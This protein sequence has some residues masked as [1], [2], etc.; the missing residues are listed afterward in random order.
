MSPSDP[1]GL[2]T[3]VAAS[4]RHRRPIRSWWAGLHSGAGSC[5]PIRRGARSARPSQA[6]GVVT[7]R[8]G[9]CARSPR[10]GSTT[11][12]NR[13]ESRGRA[14]GGPVRRGSP[15]QRTRPEAVE[16][17]PAV[18]EYFVATHGEKAVNVSHSGIVVGAGVC[19][20]GLGHLCQ[21]GCCG[22]EPRSSSPPEWRSSRS[23]RMGRAHHGTRRPP[24]QGAL[25]SPPSRSQLG[26]APTADEQCSAVAAVATG[27]FA[28]ASI[29]S[30]PVRRFQH[31]SAC[32]PSAP[33]LG[34][35]C[36]R[37]SW[38]SAE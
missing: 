31:H 4:D 6:L 10:A 27:R 1:A 37:P 7:V 22:L 5:R 14:C 2:L 15:A 12:M 32:R 35:L 30:V 20:S 29:P 25:A 28:T 33:S 18:D 23:R 8:E 26:V 24:R 21:R 19:R 11:G 36:G 17:V 16:R 3:S 34:I 9:R 13:S 38:R